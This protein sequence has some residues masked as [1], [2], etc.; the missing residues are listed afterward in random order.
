[1]AR[2][3]ALHGAAGLVWRRGDRIG[4]TEAGMPLLDALLA[5]LVSDALVSA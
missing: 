4:I 3:L 2:K 5:E 1:D